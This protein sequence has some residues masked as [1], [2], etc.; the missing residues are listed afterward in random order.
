MPQGDAIPEKRD[1]RAEQEAAFQ[2]PG[3]LDARVAKDEH[4]QGRTR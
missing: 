3:Y 4:D 1:M 2:K